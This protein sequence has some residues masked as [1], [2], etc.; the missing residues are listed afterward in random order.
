MPDLS[1]SGMN[2]LNTRREVPQQSSRGSESKRRRKEAKATDTDDEISHFFASTEAPHRKHK[3]G[4]SRQTAENASNHIDLSTNRQCRQRLSTSISSTPVANFP[5]RPFL[6]RPD[7]SQPL[8]S[9]RHSLSSRKTQAYQSPSLETT[10]LPWSTSPN[11]PS[12]LLRMRKTDEIAGSSFQKAN[13]NISPSQEPLLRQIT[14]RVSAEPQP[15]TSVG[16]EEPEENKIEPGADSCSKTYA[17]AGIICTN[18]P[19]PGTS[20]LDG[21]GEVSA[22]ENNKDQINGLPS[23]QEVKNTDAVEAVKQDTLKQFT[24]LINELLDKW[25]DKVSVPTGIVR[26]IQDPSGIAP[27]IER[28]QSHTSAL[29]DGSHLQEIIGED[30]VNNKEDLQHVP[31]PRPPSRS[32]GNP[33]YSAGPD[34]VVVR[35]GLISSQ[36]STRSQGSWAGQLAEAAQ[37]HQ[38]GISSP[39]HDS[40]YSTCRGTESIY[41]QQMHGRQQHLRYAHIPVRNSSAGASTD[42]IVGFRDSPYQSTFAQVR[43]PTLGEKYDVPSISHTNQYW[44]SPGLELRQSMIRTP[45][46][47]PSTVWQS[48]HE[49]LEYASPPTCRKKWRNPL[50]TH[51]CTDPSPSTT[52]NQNNSPRGYVLKDAFQDEMLAEESLRHEFCSPGRALD[53]KDSREELQIGDEGD[54]EMEIEPSSFWKPNLLY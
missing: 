33:A 23:V 6:G 30:I 7:N 53:V 4:N 16:D 27:V 52:L 5:P 18:T 9:R 37:H 48:C 25:K 17:A 3:H 31:S 13:P 32:L 28:P 34:V 43:T 49:T 47:P 50:G 44:E 46:Q 21:H 2:F 51:L 42:F 19:H 38:F 40:S 39:F 20:C 26:C 10:Y 29:H 15:T 36:H 24:V 8:G 14:R 22:S 35:R 41:E 12:S 54:E 1:F 11:R 45:A